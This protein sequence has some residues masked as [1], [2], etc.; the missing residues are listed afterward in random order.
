M[1]DFE[2]VKQKANLLDL[3][4][5]LKK[6]ASTGG[7]EYAGSCPFCGGIDRF[8]VQTGQ[9]IW[10]CRHCTGGVWRDVTDFVARRD[11]KSL[12]E[13][14]YSLGADHDQKRDFRF[15]AAPSFTGGCKTKLD[16]VQKGGCKTAYSPP[17][18]EWQQK[19]TEAVKI[20]KAN[21][22]SDENV[23][24]LNYLHRRG[25]KD[26]TI[27]RFGLGYSPGFDYDGLW[28]PHGVTIPAVINGVLWYVK[29]RTN[30]TNPKYTLVKGS[31]PAALYN[32]DDLLKTK[33]CLIVEGEFNCMVAWQETQLIDDV[34]SI[35]SMGAAGNRPDLATWGPYFITKDL[36]LALFDDDQAGDNGAVTLHQT[37]G[38]LVKFTALPPSKDMNDYLLAGGDVLS[39]LANELNFHKDSWEVNFAEQSTKGA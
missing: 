26:K 5:G 34:V 29:I 21:L 24:A 19:A 28:I 9:N 37:L 4:G 6:V 23:K 32:G 22:H 31:K 25:L 38:D 18:Q 27:E 8:R 33:S 13:A 30:Q 12:A 16:Q 20:C 14:A 7:G 1:I 35:A 36:I 17:G 15:T 10:L 2:G 11:N 3:V 39:W